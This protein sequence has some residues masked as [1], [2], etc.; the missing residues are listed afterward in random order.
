M[1][2]EKKIN[3]RAFLKLGALGALGLGIPPMIPGFRPRRLFADPDDPILGTAKNCVVILL[4]GAASHVDTF[5]LQVYDGITPE[6]YDAREYRPGIVWPYGTLPLLGDQLD[7]IALIRSLEV[8][9]LEHNMAQYHLEALTRLN[10]AFAGEIP[11]FGS[12]IARELEAPVE[13]GYILPPFFY[14]GESAPGFPVRQGFLDAIYAPFLIPDPRQQLENLDQGTHFEER[15]EFLYELDTL[16]AEPARGAGLTAYDAFYR[17]AIPLA[18]SEEVK[19][20]FDVSAD[21]SRYGDNDFGAGCA[22]ARNL[23]DARLGTRFVLLNL[24]GWDF[25]QNIYGEGMYD[26]CRRLDMGAGNLLADLAALPGETPGRSL[27]DDTLVVCMTEFGRT[28]GRLNETSGRDHYGSCFSFWAAG[29]GVVGGRAIGTTNGAEILDNGWSHDRSI[30]IEDIG[31]TIYS[32]LGLDWTTVIEDTPSGRP[33]RYI[34]EP[35]DG[36]YHVVRELFA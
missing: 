34:Y 5:D 35:T 2:Q 32:A 36:Y 25:H 23:L 33:F 6:E 4:R 14:L 7:R 3:R 12:V 31:V 29:G 24:D 28:P 30:R 17:R 16:R 8:D 15:V 13:E 26:I 1:T 10:P 11:H 27:L 19:A 22:V 21:L 20:I 18:G 9:Q